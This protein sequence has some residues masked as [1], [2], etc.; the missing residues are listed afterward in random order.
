VRGVLAIPSFRRLW[1]VTALASTGDWLS[2]LALSALA[3]Q[4]TT[5]YQAQSFAL[6]GVVATRLLPALVLGPLAGV[7][8]D[9]FDRRKL[10]VICDLARFG[11]FFSIPLVG[12]LWW[13]FAA[14]FLIE[15]CSMFWIPA[16]DASIPNLLRRKD[17][18]ETANQLSL[19]MTYGVAVIVASGLFTA[20]STVGKLI[21]EHP[22]PTTTVYIALM[23]NG[24]GYLLTALTVWAAIP[25]ISGRSPGRS[26]E[27]GTGLLALLH[28]G[29]R[30]VGSTPLVRGLVIGIMG[31][32]AAGGAV[33][34]LAKL[35]ATNLGGGNAAYGMLFVSVFIGMATGMGA[36][37]RLA[38]RLPH[39]RLFGSAIVAA[40]LSLVLVALAPH[41]IVALVTVALVG[42][43]AGVAFLTGLTIIGSQVA[44]EVRGRVVAFVQS[45]VRL[46]LLASMSVAPVAVG[47]VQTRTIDVFGTPMNVDGTRTVLGIAGL[48]A[49]VVGVLAYRQMD[50]RR[51]EPLL[52]DLLGALR[53]GDRRPVGG[54]LIAVEGGVAGE[55]AEQAARLV[56]RLRA[57]GYSVAQRGELDAD[58]RLLLDT[59]LA[60]ELSGVRA[61][62]L[63][64]AAVRADVVEREIRPALRAGEIVVVDGFLADP[65]A[66]LG[67]AVPE[68]PGGGAER[69]EMDGAELTSLA[70]WATGRLRPDVTVL[71]DRAPTGT[72]DPDRGDP[73]AI[74]EEHLPVR[75][76]LTRMA[77][78][79]PHRYVVVDADAP[80]DDVHQ[81]VIDGIRPVV[82][83]AVRR[84]ATPAPRAR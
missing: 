30:F 4:L 56:D 20:V 28:D 47:L 71:L 17:Q 26:R 54:V 32:F 23:I 58:A 84:R 2:L 37:P 33:I 5:G 46:D 68:Q 31:A 79:E 70:S 35:Y 12:S 19:A 25:E 78:A 72:D 76:W 53:R 43:C 63:A 9:K 50:D 42:C 82:R 29:A 10:M 40:G 48:I 81:R 75:R 14:T 3:T 55:S 8:A 57:E 34:A 65:L 83:T 73:L 61:R 6:G 15:I 27:P 11:L 1:L 52:P 49:S 80:P 60:G 22:G 74:A 18:V 16:K 66:G 44:N 24:S 38:R 13:L 51:S 77:A 36:A 41:L 62:A 59:L 64:A 7:L 69:A 21:G 45:I 67:A 39:N